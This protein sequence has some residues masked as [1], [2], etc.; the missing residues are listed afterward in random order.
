MATTLTLA[1]KQRRM[2]DFYNSI[3]QNKMIYLAVGYSNEWTNNPPVPEETDTLAT[4]NASILGYQ[5]YKEILFAKVIQNPTEEDKNTKVYYKD[6][7]YD[8][9]SDYQQAL[10]E[11]YTRIMMRFVLD[12]DEY[13][14]VDDGHGNATMYNLLGMYMNVNPGTLSD[15][16]YISPEDW[17]TRVADEG[18]LELISTRSIISRAADQKEE[19]AIL[20]E[21]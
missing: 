9:I 18:V 10:D 1:S 6:C 19:I 7:Y 2:M 16:Y 17:E 8:T 14:P 13:F 15:T 3:G 21:F 11:G 5:T 12:K 4:Y 20:C